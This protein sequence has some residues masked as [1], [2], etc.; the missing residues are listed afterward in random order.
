VTISLRAT[1]ETSEGQFAHAHARVVPG[2]SPEGSKFAVRLVSWVEDVVR[3]A[4]HELFRVVFSAG[5]ASPLVVVDFGDEPS[6]PIQVL[7]HDAQ[8]F[9]TQ[10]AALVRRP[11]L[12]SLGKN[13]ATPEFFREILR[14][15]ERAELNSSYKI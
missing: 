6:P 9:W 11:R 7:A 8:S 2:S 4:K 10:A 12:G 15:K 3:V 13:L 5:P 1:G 14:I